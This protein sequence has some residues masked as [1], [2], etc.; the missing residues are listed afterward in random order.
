[1]NQLYL[2]DRVDFAEY[3]RHCNLFAPLLSKP[4]IDSLTCLELSAEKKN[5]GVE[6]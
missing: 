2:Y 3:V 1:M 4:R 6:R 5:R